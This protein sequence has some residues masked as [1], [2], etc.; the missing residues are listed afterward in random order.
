MLISVTLL[1]IIRYGAK[2][3]EKQEYI[4][5]ACVPTAY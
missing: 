5:I 1:P 3:K 4:E 2:Y